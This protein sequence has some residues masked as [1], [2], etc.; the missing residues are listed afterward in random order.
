MT[1]PPAENEND[2]RLEP[3]PI[4]ELFDVADNL[5]SSTN[6][7]MSAYLSPR[8]AC[9]RN[10]APVIQ[11]RSTFSSLRFNG[12]RGIPY[13]LV[14]E[15]HSYDVKVEFSPFVLRPCETVKPNSYSDE[16]GR[17]HCLPGYTEDTVNGTGY[18]DDLDNYKVAG[19]ELYKPVVFSEGNWLEALHPYGICVPCAN[20]YF[21]PHPGSQPCTKCEDRF[22]TSRKDGVLSPNHTSTSNKTLPGALGRT[23]EEDC[24]CIVQLEPPFDTY[25]RNTSTHVKYKCEHCPPGG[26][27][28]GLGIEE[29]GALP[30]FYRPSERRQNSQSVPT[31]RRV[32]AAS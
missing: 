31:R 11:G 12:E 2:F 23:S 1:E 26:N 7:F 5:C 22:D 17:C 8:R 15:V 32:W 29:I 10:V 19:L 13:T 3:Q 4:V 18:V 16:K 28:S 24:H 9:S 30:G 14:F 25:F 21:K 27:C 6:T 20:G